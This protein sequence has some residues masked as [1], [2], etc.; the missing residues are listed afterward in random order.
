MLEIKPHT[1]IALPMAQATLH[2]ST[3]L[4]NAR[5]T[6]LG[7]TPAILLPSIA[8]LVSGV[9]LA[10]TS[11]KRQIFRLLSDQDGDEAGEAVGSCRAFV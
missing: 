4:S 6:L 10:R 9:Y 5:G 2:M 8:S 3:H 7:T 11:T 1:V